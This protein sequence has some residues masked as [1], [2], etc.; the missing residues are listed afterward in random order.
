MHNLHFVHIIIGINIML[1]NTTA[2][3]KQSYKLNTLII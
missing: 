2:S 3:V 1:Y